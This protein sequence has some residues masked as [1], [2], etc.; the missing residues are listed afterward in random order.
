M[1]ANKV[2]VLLSLVSINFVEKAGT[3]RCLRVCGSLQSTKSKVGKWVP[4]VGSCP[5]VRLIGSD[6]SMLGVMAM[7]EALDLAD[8]EGVDVVLIS[9]D[10]EPPV[11][12]LIDYSKYKYELAKN[13]KEAQKKQRESRS[14]CLLAKTT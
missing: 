2:I 6:K 13:A 11:A 14:V 8:E 3:P 12:R 1:S 5:E 7:E 9:P 10:A 4:G